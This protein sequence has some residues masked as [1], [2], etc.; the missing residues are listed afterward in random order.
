MQVLTET[1]RPMVKFI[2]GKDGRRK[3]VVVALSR[4]EIGVSMCRDKDR[5]EE[6]AEDLVAVQKGDHFDR[7]RGITIAV[8]RAR[9]KIQP[10]NLPKEALVEY[11]LMV[12]RAE[13][14]YK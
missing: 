3:G 13:R 10:K 9:N 1:D 14:Y 11:Q 5:I 4:T 7:E 6:L 2:H 12:N 8:G